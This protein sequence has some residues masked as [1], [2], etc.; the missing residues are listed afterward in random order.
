MIN[1]E[2][3]SATECARLTELGMDQ[4][5]AAAALNRLGFERIQDARQA[6]GYAMLIHAR[7][8]HRADGTPPLWD[9]EKGA[10]VR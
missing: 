2:D 10:W 8:E 1:P 5:S 9:A 3:F 7:H 6:L 4:S